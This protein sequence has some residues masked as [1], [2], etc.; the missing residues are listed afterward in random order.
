LGQLNKK[1]YKI[2]VCLFFKWKKGESDYYKVRHTQKKICNVRT[3]NSKVKE[4]NTGAYPQ[5]DWK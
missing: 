1:G 4:Q 5:C 3:S 2:G